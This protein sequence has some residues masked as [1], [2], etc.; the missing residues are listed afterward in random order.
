MR[1]Q[2]RVLKAHSRVFIDGIARCQP[3]ANVRL[4]PR[5]RDLGQTSRAFIQISS[6]RHDAEEHVNLSLPVKDVRLA[7]LKD[8]FGCAFALAAETGVSGSR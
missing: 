6:K 7:V 4:E 8:T 3:E 1:A 2:R 5:D